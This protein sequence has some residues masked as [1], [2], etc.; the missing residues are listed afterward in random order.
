MRIVASTFWRCWGHLFPGDG[1][2]SLVGHL[3]RQHP[4]GTALPL[5]ETMIPYVKQI[6]AAL[7]YAHDQNVDRRDIKPEKMRWE[8]TTSARLHF[9]LA[10]VARST[11]S[12]EEQKIG[13]AAPYMLRTFQAKAVRPVT[14]IRWWFPSTNGNWS[15]PFDEGDFMQ[16]GYQHR[17]EPSGPC[18]RKSSDYC[19]QEFEQVVMKGLAKEPGQRF[20][21]IEAFANALEQTLKPQNPIIV[22]PPTPPKPA[23]VSPPIGTTLVTFSGHTGCGMGSCLGARWYTYR[24]R[25]R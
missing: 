13:R 4:K 25:F 5:V 21:R 3:R 7:Q 9:G 11:R 23:I 1:L 16:L 18:A 12:W 6:A 24:F 19:H 10:V 20:E 2:C 8:S 14:N 17:Y 15:P 22:T